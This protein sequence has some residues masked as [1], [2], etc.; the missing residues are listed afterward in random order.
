[1]IKYTFTTTTGFGL[2]A[3]GH[4]QIALTGLDPSAG[5]V[6]VLLQYILKLR[7]TFTHNFY[8]MVE[9][10]KIEGREGGMVV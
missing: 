7:Y 6:L 4:H 5:Q 9:L 8:C 10:V 1:M 2:L 3:P